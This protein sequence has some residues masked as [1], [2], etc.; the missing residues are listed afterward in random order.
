MYVCMYVC[1]YHVCAMWICACINL[2]DTERP[3][4]SL[5]TGRT[6]TVSGAVNSLPLELD[7]VLDNMN[8]LG[9]SSAPLLSS[10]FNVYLI[11]NGAK[12]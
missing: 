3:E 4:N 5:F 7:K 2:Q 12:N 11:A 8:V 1:M 9:V 10:T 6:V